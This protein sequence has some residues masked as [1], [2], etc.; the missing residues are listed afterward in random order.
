MVNGRDHSGFP[1]ETTSRLEV[2]TTFSANLTI[3]SQKTIKYAI[4]IATFYLQPVFHHS[5]SVSF[6]TSSA[7]CQN[8]T[9]SAGFHRSEGAYD[10]F[11]LLMDNP[12]AKKIFRQNSFAGIL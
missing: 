9:P 7:P 12:R 4:F 1:P 5:L 6:F 2:Y 3:F 11:L 10:R 8:E